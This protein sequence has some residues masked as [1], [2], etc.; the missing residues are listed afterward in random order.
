MFP[1]S[2]PATQRSNIRFVL[3]P[4]LGWLGILFLSSS[5]GFFGETLRAAFINAAMRLTSEW[6][7][8]LAA[9]KA[10][11]V[12]RGCLA[13]MCHRFEHAKQMCVYGV[14]WTWNHTKCESCE[15]IEWWWA[16]SL[17]WDFWRKVLITQYLIIRMNWAM[18]DE[19]MTIRLNLADESKTWERSFPASDKE[20]GQWKLN[21]WVQ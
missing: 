5:I 8:I 19:V 6:V 11:C 2:W 9:D 21:T 7:S 20:N 12:R 4:P 10:R 13:I 16:L 1:Y 3:W 15:Q 18:T 17:E 14:H